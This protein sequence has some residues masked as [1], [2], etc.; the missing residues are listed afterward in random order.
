MNSKAKVYGAADSIKPYVERAMSDEKLR[1]DVF[2]AF[3]T[4]NELYRELMSDR[5]PVAHRD[6]RRDRRRRPRQAA[7]GDRGSAQRERPPQG[8]ARPLDPQ[9]DAAARRASRSDCSTTRSPGPETRRFI[10]D[11]LERR[12]SSDSGDDATAG[13]ANGRTLGRVRA[14]RLAAAPA[15]PRSRGAA[16]P[17]RGRPRSRC[18]RP[19]AGSRPAAARRCRRSTLGAQPAAPGTAGAAAARARRGTASGRS[20]RRSRGRA[21]RPG[22]PRSGGASASPRRRR[23]CP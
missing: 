22:A 1:G 15:A 19:R 20:R 10:K 17:G 14:R 12:P 3:R 23:C 8:Q 16:T 6:A 2:S 21:A 4:A 9:H 11:M 7:R 18:R 5:E 13:S